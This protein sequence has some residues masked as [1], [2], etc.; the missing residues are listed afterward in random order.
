MRLAYVFLPVADLDES[1][2][3]YETLGAIVSWRTNRTAILGVPDLEVKLMLN[4]EPAKDGTSAGLMFGVESVTDTIGS[5]SGKVTFKGKP[6]PVPG[7]LCVEGYDNSG[8]SLQFIDNS[9]ED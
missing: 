4:V 5:L 6:F 1:I 7:G 3:F 9:N 8:H 2:K